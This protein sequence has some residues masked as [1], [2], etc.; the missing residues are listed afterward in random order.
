MNDSDV[1]KDGRKEL[2]NI[3]VIAVSF[4]L[5]QNRKHSKYPSKVS[6]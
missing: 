3:L 6:G 4:I 2:G 5:A 1:V